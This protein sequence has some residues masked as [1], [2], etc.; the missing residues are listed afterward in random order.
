MSVGPPNHLLARPQNDTVSGFEFSA[1]VELF[2]MLT[3]G[4]EAGI[5]IRFTHGSDKTTGLYE[6]F[7]DKRQMRTYA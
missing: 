7:I 4:Q 2:S 5:L 6:R 1:L 3:P